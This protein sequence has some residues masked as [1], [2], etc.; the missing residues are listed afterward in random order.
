MTDHTS[1]CISCLPKNAS[2]SIKEG[3]YLLSPEQA[4]NYLARI[5]IIREPYARLRSMYGFLKREGMEGNA[6]KLAPSDSWE[7]FIDHVLRKED[8]HWSSQVEL[9]GGIPTQWFRFEDLRKIWPLYYS[10]ALPH[11]NSSP[12]QAVNEYRSKEL[13]SKYRRDIDLWKSLGNTRYD[14]AR[15]V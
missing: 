9:L 10:K 12:V 13:E 7:R 2:T 8:P 4:A 3:S 14:E 15:N 11:T 6:H 1:V 5:G